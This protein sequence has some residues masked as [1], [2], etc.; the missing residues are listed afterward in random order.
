MENNNTDK[1]KESKIS[2]RSYRT[3]RVATSAILIAVGLVLSYLNPFAYFTLFGTKI[4]PFAHLINAISGV[5]LGTM[6]ALVVAL[7]IA[8]LRFSLGIGTIHAFHGGMSGALVVGLV[9]R[10]LWRRKIEKVEIAAF[11]EPLGTVF[12]GGTIAYLIA[13]FGGISIFE[14]LLIYW[15]LFAASCIPG[16]ILG[17]II[18]VFLKRSGIS[19]ENFIESP[20]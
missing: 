16:S 7:G 10:F 4:N 11:F 3:I 5:L 1:I 13:P 6:F 17:Y 18:L 2:I 8:I 20:H 15:G 9:S 19:R 14:G 12:I